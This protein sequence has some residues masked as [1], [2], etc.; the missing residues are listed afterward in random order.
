MRFTHVVCVCWKL[1]QRWEQYERRVSQLPPHHLKVVHH[2]GL[3][4]TNNVDLC[5]PRGLVY[6]HS[7][8]TTQRSDGEEGFLL[9][10]EDGS[11]WSSV[12]QRADWYS[13]ER[14]S[15]QTKWLVSVELQG[16]LTEAQTKAPFVIQ[17]VNHLR[18]Q[19]PPQ[20]WQCAATSPCQGPG[21]DRGS[22]AVQPPTPRGRGLTPCRAAPL[23]GEADGRALGAEDCGGAFSGWGRSAGG[24]RPAQHY[25]L[26]SLELFES[27]A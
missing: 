20:V 7:T 8:T 26:Q 3:S 16:T 13:A 24:D 1:V 23:R 4:E 11:L 6:T 27:Y 25:G 9:N 2:L 17:F 18:I 19:S 10:S 14:Y 22:S 5:S 21:A 15:A 12:H